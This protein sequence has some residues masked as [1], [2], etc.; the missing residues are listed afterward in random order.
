MKRRFP[1]YIYGEIH[2]LF[3]SSVQKY[4]LSSYNV[5]SKHCYELAYNSEQ[6]T[7][8]PCFHGDY[9]LIGEDMKETIK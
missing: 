6:E 1:G 4:V 9:I 7:E 5:I 2:S 3:N 8:G